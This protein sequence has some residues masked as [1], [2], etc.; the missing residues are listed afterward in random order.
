MGRKKKVVEE[1][2]VKPVYGFNLLA[3][4]ETV[5]TREPGDDGWDRGDTSTSWWVEDVDFTTQE[6]SG[7][8][9]HFIVP[10]FDLVFPLLQSKEFYILYG[11]YSTGDSF[12]HDD[13]KYLEV[14]EVY[15]ELCDAEQAERQL[16][17][18]YRLA[19]E[20]RY[21]GYG[22]GSTKKERPK[23]FNDYSCEII[24]GDGKLFTCHTPWVG[25]FDSLD[26]LCIHSFTI[27]D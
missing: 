24:G 4:S 1:V 13:R 18:H 11:I 23:D 8:G 2:V 20:G 26:D 25:Y 22:S 27:G 16:Q 5:N 17:D 14:I 15:Q 12:G 7:Y 19:R 6:G 3:G 10:K 9:E 21:G